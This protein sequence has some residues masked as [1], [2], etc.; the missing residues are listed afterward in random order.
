M[1]V[2]VKDGGRRLTSEGSTSGDGRSFFIQI[3][4]D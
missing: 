4:K 3:K 2:V 1:I